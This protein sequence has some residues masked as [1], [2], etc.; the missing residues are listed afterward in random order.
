MQ[1]ESN[2]PNDAYTTF[3]GVFSSPRTKR[4]QSMF[5][6]EIWGTLHSFARRGVGMGHHRGCP[7]SRVL[8]EMWVRS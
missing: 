8:C 1:L 7:I 6:L 5:P 2:H 4:N 3:G